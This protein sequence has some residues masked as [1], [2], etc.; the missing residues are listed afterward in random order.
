MKRNLAARDISRRTFLGQ[1]VWAAAGVVAGAQAATRPA[2][3]T[4]PALPRPCPPTAWQKHGIV[5]EPTEPW[6]G[7]HIQN[8]TCPAESLDND[9]W[10]IWYS[11]V[12]PKL[13][14]TVAYAEGVPGGP[15]RKF[16]AQCTP[17]QA[18]DG[19]L[20]IGNLPEEWKPVQVIH[21]RLRDG[22]HR[23]YFWV[24]AAEIVRYL[25]ADSD[26]GRRYR[27]IDPQRPVLYHPHD[28]AA[29]GIASPDG[30]MLVKDRSKNRPPQEPVAPAHLISNDATNIYQLP[31]GSFELYSVGL[32]PVAKD[33][34][35][36]VAEDN[37]AGLVR[38]ID[39]Y[40]SADGL[41]FENRQR[42]IQRDATDPADQQ[43]YYLAVTCTPKGRVGML[44]HYRVQ[45]Q[46]MDLEWCFSNDGMKWHRP[47]RAAWLA[48]GDTT[49]P[50]SYGIYGPNHLVHRDGRYHLFYTA[51]NSAHNHKHSH[52]PPRTVVMYATA[53]SIWA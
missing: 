23:I 11:A 13:G 17:G 25:A 41:H 51:A 20:A 8:F 10:R 6:E 30:M 34:P 38:V 39:R 14:Y 40:T 49:Q 31:D 44:G 7:G 27:V 35:A 26:D 21:L 45:A 19:A 42:V 33:N 4:E 1:T 36:Y 47:D 48:R 37:A 46:T 22:K 52:G 50:D 12:D 15:M 24:H 53:D 18:G 28:R 16:P 9:R 2:S 32:V 3:Q 29:H 5:L 43:F